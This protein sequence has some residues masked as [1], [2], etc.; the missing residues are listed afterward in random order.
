MICAWAE[1]YDICSLWTKPNINTLQKTHFQHLLHGVHMGFAHPRSL[2]MS[3]VQD[4]SNPI[5][6]IKAWSL[7]AEVPKL[8]VID[9]THRWL[10]GSPEAIFDLMR[11]RAYHLTLAHTCGTSSRGV[12]FHT[13]LLNMSTLI[14]N[15][16]SRFG[17]WMTSHAIK[18]HFH[19]S[20][21]R[22]SQ[23]QVCHSEYEGKQRQRNLTVCCDV[24]FFFVFLINWSSFVPK[25]TTFISFSL[26]GCFLFKL[27]VLTWTKP[28][29]LASF[30]LHTNM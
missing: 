23:C 15:I 29:S 19:Q 17:W 28:G 26:V 8:L 14:A 4:T 22:E 2:G 25:D 16:K 11:L 18:C 3:I 30:S 27:P 10:W 24:F 13:L 9:L 5:K 20:L 7:S 6:N 12:L 1:Q 21:F